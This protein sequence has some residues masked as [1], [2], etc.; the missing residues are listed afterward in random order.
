MSRIAIRARRAATAAGA[1]LLLAAPAAGAASPIPGAAVPT[2]R[3]AFT[4]TPATAQ[5]IRGVP[6]TPQNPFMAPNGKSNVHNDAWMTDA[7]RTG[8]PLGRS[9][10][11][12]SAVLD[13]RVCITITFD[14]RGRLVASCISATTG[15]RL[16]MLDPRTLDTLAQFA[17]PA[18]P[19][20]AGI[21]PAL[22]TAGGAY[23][24]L[25][26]RDRAVL[27]TTD[28]RIWVV[29][30][31]GG[32]TNPGFRKV[33]EYSVARYLK[34]DERLPSTLPDWK[35]RLWFVGRQ[36]GTVGVLDPA[37]GRAKAI[38]LGEEI[39]NSFATSPEGV[40]V[41]SDKRMY[42]MEVGRGGRP[43]IVWR[44]RYDNSGVKKPGQINAGTGTTPTVM[45]G[46]YVAIT[47]N[48]DP[49]QVVVY[50]R[51][52]K[53]RRGQRRVVCEVPVFSEGTQRHR[54]LAHHRG[55]LARRREQLRLRAR[56]DGGRQAHR[57]RDRARRRAPRRPRLSPRVDEPDGA[58]A[59]RRAEGVA[60]D[61]ARLRLH[62]GPGP[63]PA[64]RRRVVLGG[65]GLPHREARVEARGGH[66]RRLQQ[67]LR[68]H[69]PGARRPLRLPRRR[70][71]AD[72]DPRRL[73]SGPPGRMTGV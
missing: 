30:E 35:G 20:A 65:A 33:R 58:R 72:G 55:P 11:V 62:Q 29:E 54:E 46:G 14:R 57:A 13:N 4:G 21:P 25:D 28:Q 51:A 69:R 15:P 44:S 53:L 1:L 7:Y 10:S 32:T 6:L 40:Y 47:D 70:G 37:T 27:A 43:R 42:R 63:G 39:E 73:L 45:A 52:A 3:P 38:R 23:F 71:R 68:R 36:S 12:F 17:L 66:R 9:P 24:F 60:E 67:P 19:P 41:A 31:T 48:A 64:H 16:Y 22:N 5:P 34:G 56:R 8:G 50:R 49:M 61:G 26:H 59:E 18:K 2:T